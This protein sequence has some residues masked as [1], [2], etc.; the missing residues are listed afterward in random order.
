MRDIFVKFFFSN[1]INDIYFLGAASISLRYGSGAEAAPVV[2]SR[3][4]GAGR[5]EGWETTG[6]TSSRNSFNPSEAGP[7]SSS[8]NRSSRGAQILNT[9]SSSRGASG[10]VNSKPVMVSSMKVLDTVRSVLG[11]PGQVN[12]S[13]SLP[14]QT[15]SISSASGALAVKLGE[16]YYF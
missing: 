8:I 1:L 4:V 2:A 14:Q 3:P 6:S 9:N 16:K 15:C 5:V 13:R 7:R 12:Y 10:S 11:L